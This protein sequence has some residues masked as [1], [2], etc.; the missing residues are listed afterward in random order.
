MKFSEIFYY[1]E[2]SI[3]CL[4]WKEDIYAGKNYNI[5]R[6]S[7]GDDCGSKNEKYFLVSYKNKSYKSHRVIWEITHGPIK[8]GFVIDH[9]DGNYLNNKISNL[10]CVT[11]V[12]NTRNA[13]KNKTNTSGITGVCLHKSTHWKAQWY[14]DGKVKSKYFSINK[15]GDEQAKSLAIQYR[16]SKIDELNILGYSYSERHGT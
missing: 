8:K 9:I 10:R 15:E 3:T 2:T 5:K 7:K 13:K 11:H 6:A 12:V 14:E 4:K 1:D 16:K